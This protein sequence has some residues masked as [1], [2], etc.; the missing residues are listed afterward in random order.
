MMTFR[1]ISAGTDLQGFPVDARHE[2]LRKRSC[3]LPVSR[4]GNRYAH[5]IV[6]DD[7]VWQIEL[8]KTAPSITVRHWILL[9]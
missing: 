6:V 9:I 5:S 8:A 3:V 2:W 1:V 4:G 7:D